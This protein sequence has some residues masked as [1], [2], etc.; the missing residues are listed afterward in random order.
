MKK[1][2]NDISRI[3]LVCMAMFAAV[4]VYDV[5]AQSS[6]ASKRKEAME[7]WKKDMAE[8]RSRSKQDNEFKALVDSISYV[9]ASAAINN[10][11]FV[12]EADNVSFKN[13]RTVFVNSNTNFIAVKGKRA[14]VQVSPSDFS[15]GP[16]GL[17][18]VTVDGAISGMKVN[19]DKK[20]RVTVSM[21]VTGIGINA[22]VEIFMDPNTNEATATVYPNFNSRTVWMSGK[23][24]PYENSTV[25]QGRSL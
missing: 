23:I 2:F 3:L 8:F 19:S 21:N 9:Q 16:N 7:T 10:M 6:R 1:K 17:G 12:L 24:I 22:Q 4:S 15:S 11:D 20:G 14:T 18:G 13:G 5:S 25:I